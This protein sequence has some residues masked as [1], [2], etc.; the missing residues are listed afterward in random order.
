MVGLMGV[1]RGKTRVLADDWRMILA[2]LNFVSGCLCFADILRGNVVSEPN[3]VVAQI[4]RM[5]CGVHG[6]GVDEQHYGLAVALPDFL[7]G[8]GIGG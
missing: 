6:G 5:P 4:K 3:L 1:V 2:L 7:R 8:G